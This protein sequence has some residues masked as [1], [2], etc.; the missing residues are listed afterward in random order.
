[1]N[2]VAL[3][4][5]IS[6]NTVNRMIAE[7]NKLFNKDIIL[8]N[9]QQ[10][11]MSERSKMLAYVKLFRDKEKIFTNYEI[12]HRHTLMI[13][14]ILVSSDYLSLQKLADICLVSKN[15]I[16]ND[17]KVLKDKLDQKGLDINYSRKT[18]YSIEGLEFMI[19]N[20]LVTA[21]KD[22]L[23]FP[24]GRILLEEQELITES[25]I[26]LLRKRLE[27]VEDRIGITLTDEQLDELPYILQLVIKR[28]YTFN[29]SWSFKVERYDIKNTAEYPQI[30]KMFWD[31]PE[32]NENDLL[33]LSLQIL[34]SNMVESAL[35]IS[36]SDEITVA[37]DQFIDNITGYLAINVAKKYELKEKIMLHMRP[38][39][40]RNLLGFQI[41]NPLTE[42]FIFEYGEVYNIVLKSV[43]PFE[44]IIH[45]KLSKQEVVYLSMIVLS[46]IYQNEESNPIF[47]AVVLCQSGT[48]ISKLLLVTLRSMFPEI[49][50]LGAFSVRQFENSR[51]DIDFIFS[52]VPVESD[53]PIFLIPPVI[54]KQKRIELRD[55]VNKKVN[56]NSS[57]ITK[58]LISSI[59]DFIPE[60]NFH[61]V[62]NRIE[63]FFEQD[64]STTMP[65]ANSEE[66]FV[67]SIDNI[68]LV[69]EKVRWEDVVQ[70]AMTPL[71]KRK[72][73]TENYIKET[74]KV[75]YKQYE[76]MI[77][78]PDVYLPHVNPIYGAIKMDFQVLIFKNPPMTPSGEKVR[79]VV[80]LSPSVDNEH[81]PTLIKL[82][83]LFLNSNTL[84]QIINSDNIF[85]TKNILTQEDD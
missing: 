54:N 36:E 66:H 64:N 19:R 60:Q 40:Y 23:N 62:S 2:E 1:M 5:D 57:Q 71:L 21:I 58:K 37:T 85:I 55:E 33:Y 29:R 69:Q 35:Q 48:S 80:A 81:V 7:I 50:F 17:L 32:L 52:T 12:E 28:A 42:E 65:S 67:F 47:N 49:D 24:A 79:I 78:A 68:N 25:E 82:N 61:Q 45:Q 10:V 56:T 34:S 8:A 75:F 20:I 30:N 3:K 43:G 6:E 51:E 11:Y 72:S 63:Q 14:K 26:Y 77:I 18:G 53:I 84:S 74:E 73:I 15:T 70:Y 76:Q 16:L 83:N 59:K 38:A 13:I 22:M 39:I 27:K 4:F 41:N 31:Y 9:N 46:W 44:Q